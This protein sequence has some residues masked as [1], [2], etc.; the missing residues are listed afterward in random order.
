MTQCEKSSAKKVT[1]RCR[2]SPDD[3]ATNAPSQE[4]YADMPPT[5]T[6]EELRTA[7]LKVIGENFG[8][9]EFLDAHFPKPDKPPKQE[10]QSLCPSPS[11]PT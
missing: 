4:S 7:W 10:K 1:P 2:T 3:C 11:S 9:E 8:G 6:L 5:R